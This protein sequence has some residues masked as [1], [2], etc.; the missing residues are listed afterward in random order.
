[1]GMMQDQRGIRIYWREVRRNETK[2]IQMRQIGFA[3]EKPLAI[4]L[5]SS[6]EFA[7]LS[8]K[9]VMT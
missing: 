6:Y 1:M 7:I 9:E 2:G 5:L 4:S 8:A 3:F